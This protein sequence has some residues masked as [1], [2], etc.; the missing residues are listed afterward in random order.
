[1]RTLEYL[2][3]ALDSTN[4]T[5]CHLKVIT[6]KCCVTKDII[7]VCVVVC[8]ANSAQANACHRTTLY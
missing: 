7:N 4:S 8:G 1:M 5:C 2:I 3:I 6:S